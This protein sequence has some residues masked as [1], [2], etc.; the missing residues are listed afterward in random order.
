MKE[1]KPAFQKLY[2]L[3]IKVPFCTHFFKNPLGSTNNSIIFKC[4]NEE[5][6]QNIPNFGKLVNPKV[7]FIIN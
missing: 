5:T 2:H 3:I 7:K 4:P 1:K 6:L